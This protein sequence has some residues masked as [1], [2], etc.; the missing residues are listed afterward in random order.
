[1]IITLDRRTSCEKKPKTYPKDDM[2]DV[3]KVHDEIFPLNYSIKNVDNGQVSKVLYVN[4]NALSSN[5]EYFRALFDMNKEATT[6]VLDLGLD[7]NAV[8]TCISMINS[9][10]CPT[11]IDFHTIMLML[12]VRHVLQCNNL[13]LINTLTSNMVNRLDRCGSK[14]VI[15]FCDILENNPR[16]HWK[17]QQDVIFRMSYKIDPSLYAKRFDLKNSGSPGVFN[18]IIR[19][20][21]VFVNRR[22]IRIRGPHLIGWC[23]I[24]IREHVC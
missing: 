18:K 5:F 8:E 15:L 23:I 21:E 16:L 4:K 13:F 11:V 20:C 14:D 17:L 7:S 12:E 6:S 9:T 22:I 19:I 1:M 10:D 3:I 24:R 2:L